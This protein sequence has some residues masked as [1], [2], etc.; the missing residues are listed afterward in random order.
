MFPCN[1]ASPEMLR[2]NLVIEN[3]GE[4]YRLLEHFQPWTYPQD[5]GL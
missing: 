2:T 3:L 4:K 5:A 1:T